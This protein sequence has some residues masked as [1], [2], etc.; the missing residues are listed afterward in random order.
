[1]GGE[2]GRLARLLLAV[3]LLVTV[4]PVA[5][6]AAEDSTVIV[7]SWDGMRHDYPDRGEFP[8]LARLISEGARAERLVTVFPSSTF[9]GHVSL[10]TGTHPDRH[11]IVGNHFVDR[12]RGSYRMESDADWL[13][14][15][16]IWIAA[17]RQGVV[18][19]TY[20]WVGS[21]SDWRGRGTR[22]RE[23]PFDGARP[24]ALKVDR[25]LDWLQLPEAE[26]PR[27]IMSYWAGADGI[28]HRFGPDSERV[29]AQ[30]AA[31]DLQLQ[32]LLEGLDRLD[33]WAS[34]TLLIVSD[35]GMAE[36][37]RYTDLRGLLADAGIGARVTG[38]TVAHVYLDDPADHARA[39]D[40]LAGIEGAR[41]YAGNALPEWMRLS[42]AARTGD[43]LVVASP[44]LTFS[45]PPGWE[46]AMVAA[47]SMVGWTFGSHGYPPD[48]PDMAGM[49]LAL[50][51]G[52][53]A[54]TRLPPVHQV[55]LAATVA[56]LLG[57]EPPRDSEG[58]PVPGL[59]VPV[60][61]G[62]AAQED[63]DG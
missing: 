61:A 7:L 60:A 26:R 14:A 9:P 44:P 41:A 56:G 22:Y 46:G 12:G 57:I 25:I 5:V 32:R 11:G 20:F 17:E 4:A 39:G 2:R 34:T 42:H 6:V 38:S 55:D 30:I 19:A 47:L 33:R 29:T 58:R 51:R 43:W 8:G 23:S 53:P 52:V 48:H 54:G 62:E 50:G 18:A 45:R 21:E 49:F 1:M 40:M 31:Q 35:H 10:A 15:E 24:E 16:P 28:G 59:G 13:L 3:G 37:N 36:S 63:E 27:L